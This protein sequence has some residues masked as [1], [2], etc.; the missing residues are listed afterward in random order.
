MP[1]SVS[2]CLCLPHC[3]F[4]LSLY[5]CHYAFVCL[6]MP[7]TVSQWLSLSH[8]ASL[9]SCLSHYAHARLTIHLSVSL[10]LCPSVHPTACPSACLSAC[11]S[12]CNGCNFPAL[13]ASRSPLIPNIYSPLPSFRFPLSNPPF[14]P[15]TSSIPLIP[16]LDQH[17]SPPLVLFLDFPP[18][19]CPSFFLDSFLRVPLPTFLHPFCSAFLPF[20]ILLILPPCLLLLF[21]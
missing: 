15:L 5:L 7:F 2:L 9:C 8:Y 1:L 6:T 3:S 18:L 17:A 4:S 14:I 12:I 21:P 16:I 19:S 20:F 10:G 11:L 13:T